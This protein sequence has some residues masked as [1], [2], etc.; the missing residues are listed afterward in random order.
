MSV[1]ALLLD[2]QLHCPWHCST[3]A[4]FTSANLQI[5]GK[6]IKLRMSS[7]YFILWTHKRSP[8]YLWT[9]PGQPVPLGPGGRYGGLATPPPCVVTLRSTLTPA[10]TPDNNNNNNIGQTSNH[11]KI[12]SSFVKNM[13]SKVPLTCPVF[14]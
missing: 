8:V 3:L 6:N 11:V 1:S 5:T 10:P 7:S 9:H 4:A 13:Y 12:R 14:Q 2:L